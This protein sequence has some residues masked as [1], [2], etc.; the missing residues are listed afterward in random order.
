MGDDSLLVK[1]SGKDLS[2]VSESSGFEGKAT[3]KGTTREALNETILRAVA[4]LNKTTEAARQ[5]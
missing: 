4:D 3:F 2:I 1:V 5:P